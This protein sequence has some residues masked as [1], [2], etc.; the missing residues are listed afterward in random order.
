MRYIL[1]MLCLLTLTGCFADPDGMHDRP[2]STRDAERQYKARLLQLE[3][4]KTTRQDILNIMG[5]PDQTD[6]AYR[7]IMYYWTTRPKDSDDIVRSFVIA[8][9][10][11]RDVLIKHQQYD[12]ATTFG[13]PKLPEDAMNEF[14]GIG[15]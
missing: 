11:A 8:Q 1:P 3:D 13:G 15:K 10:N 7:V 6:D 5:D 2:V 4:G 9:F 12:N 14:L